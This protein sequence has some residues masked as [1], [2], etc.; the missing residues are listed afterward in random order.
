MKE[1]LK[2]GFYL[3]FLIGLPI[4]AITTQCTGREEKRREKEIR[5]ALIDSLIKA[6]KAEK[7]YKDSLIQVQRHQFFNDFN[8]D[9]T[10]FVCYADFENWLSQTN[11]AGL[12]L[13]YRLYPDFN[14]GSN[15]FVDSEEL[16]KYLGWE[17]QEYEV[18]CGECGSYSYIYPGDE[19]EPLDNTGFIN[20]IVLDD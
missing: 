17:P 14:T 6:E 5:M 18:E 2:Y 13:L 15:S 12:E 16:S 20:D 19:Y 8:K 1:L 7:E 11:M 9:N 10:L 3:V 4:V